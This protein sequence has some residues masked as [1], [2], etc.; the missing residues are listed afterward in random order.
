MSKQH[1][2]ITLPSKSS[3]EDFPENTNNYYKTRLKHGVLLDGQYEASLASITYPVTYHNVV[4]GRNTFV[5]K[6]LSAIYV[7]R[8]PHG[9][10]SKVDDVIY[11]VNYALEEFGVDHPSLYLHRHITFAL[12]PESGCIRVRILNQVTMRTSVEF[13][14]HSVV[15]EL[16]GF[17]D[18]IEGKLSSEEESNELAQTAGAPKYSYF[19]SCPTQV[20]TIR[21]I[22]VYCNL[23]EYSLV[24]TQSAQLIR[25]I[26]T[27][28][29]FGDVVEKSFSDRQYVPVRLSEFDTVAIWLADDAGKPIEFTAG[30]VLVQLHLKK[31]W[32]V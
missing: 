12:S 20:K 23:V 25:T 16:L 19:H 24:G 14:P 28:G 11:K 7:L 15:G 29:N 8:I 13:P 21:Q 17:G 32:N 4:E 10:Y 5:V 6:F 1:F 3:S 26:A 2:Y 9:L 22:Y 18:K 31:V 30:H 27:E